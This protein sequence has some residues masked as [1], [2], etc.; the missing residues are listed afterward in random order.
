MGQG[1][2][3]LFDD[4]C[5]T[6]HV[7]GL[8]KGVHDMRS[9][10]GNSRR[11]FLIVPTLVLLLFVFMWA[12]PQQTGV[13]VTWQTETEIDSVGFYLYRALSPDGPWEQVNDVLIPARGEGVAGAAY[14]YRDKEVNAGRQYYYLLEEVD[15]R[16][17]R[18]RYG[19]VE[20]QTGRPVDRWVVLGGSVLALVGG[21]TLLIWL[22]PP[23]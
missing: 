10:S 20:A 2:C 17:M 6:C 23:R 18:T 8:R 21:A 14:R 16:G 1:Y 22:W 19:P 11:V 9:R 7:S 12:I 4:K 13:E 5:Q 15:V 3:M